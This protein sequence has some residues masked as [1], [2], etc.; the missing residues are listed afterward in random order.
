[1]GLLLAGRLARPAQKITAATLLGLGGLIA[2]PIVVQVVSD[3][4]NGPGSERGERRRLDSIRT[5][6]G[7]PE[8]ADIY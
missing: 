6:S 3:A 7:F 5:D 4:V 2:L 8:G 1:L